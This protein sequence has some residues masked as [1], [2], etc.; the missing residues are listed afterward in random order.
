[1]AGVRCQQLGPGGRRRAPTGMVMACKVQGHQR[2]TARSEWWPA[3]GGLD[4]GP[5]GQRQASSPA[6]AHRPPLYRMDP[7]KGVRH[8]AEWP[9]RGKRH[10]E[11]TQ[12]G[13]AGCRQVRIISA[14]T[15]RWSASWRGLLAAEPALIV[16]Q[17]ARLGPDDRADHIRAAAGR[18]WQ[19]WP[20]QE[21][22]GVALLAAAAKPNVLPARHIPLPE[23]AEEFAGRL[24]LI[25][26]HGG[27]NRMFL[28]L[29]VYG[30]PG[31]ARDEVFNAQ[32]LLE[33]MAQVR[34]FGR[35]PAVVMG[36]LNLNLESAGVVGLLGVSGW[37]DLLAGAG[38]TCV[39][40][41]GQPSR[42]DYALANSEFMGLVEGAELRWDLGLATHAAVQVDLL[43]TEGGSADFR[44]FPPSLAGAACPDWTQAA[45]ERAEALLVDLHG[46]VI[47]SAL[48]DG[49]VE[50]AWHEIQRGM[51]CWL[52]ERKG[53]RQG[54]RRYAAVDRREEWRRAAS[55]EGDEQDKALEAALL[56]VRRL[57]NLRHH[58]ATSSQA[59]AI[60]R[61]LQRAEPVDEG[62]SSRLRELTEENL[63]AL[64]DEARA[65][66]QAEVQASR[67]RR[68][69]AWW[70]W[71]QSNLANQQGRVYRWLRDAKDHTPSMVLLEGQET[72]P[73][74]ARQWVPAVRGGPVA[75]HQFF[76]TAWQALWQRPERPG[77]GA[78][79]LRCLTTL[80]GLPPLPGWTAGLVRQTLQAMALRKRPGLDSWSV[81]EMRSQPRVVHEWIAAL[82]TEV[83]RTGQWPREAQVPEGVLL[84]KGLINGPLARRPIWLTTMLYRLWATARSK[85]VRAWVQ[86]WCREL[87]SVGA[88]GQ[89]WMLSVLN[90]KAQVQGLEQTGAAFDWQKAY[91]GVGLDLMQ[92]A[93]VAAGLPHEVLGPLM[94]AYSSPRRIRTAGILGAEWQ[95]S[96]GLLP[97]CPLAVHMLAM[98]T[99]PWRLRM[100]LVHEALYCR[101]YVDDMTVWHS[102]PEA[103]AAEILAEARYCGLCERHGLGPQQAEDAPFRLHGGPAAMAAGPLP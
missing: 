91:D 13:P 8:L 58:P 79:E 42:L 27:R 90:A 88:D 82:L 41:R 57:E 29:N 20:G 74:A 89:A 47:A 102:G 69:E 64:L 6:A 18:G 28:V 62:G 15:T 83:E 37:H 25:A 66:L 5:D 75:Q 35:V 92:R 76:A 12:P 39:P 24:Q 38:H 48:A 86:S 10:G 98:L 51:H 17:E 95:P 52:C 63:P 3:T 67:Q 53:V 68:R 65:A 19:L 81:P 77:A 56:R 11:A 1:M 32:L 7:S 36:D 14:N 72:D 22:D 31:G 71:V 16:S 100:Q 55:R 94:A 101:I 93:G 96:R 26:V 33:G 73:A 49:E 54:M 43:L 45:Q 61:A 87:P 78:E 44:V 70:C 84:P 99:F 23:L 97:G 9:S 80:P 40:T 21:E 34:S 50:Q 60:R 4:R 85:V 103:A 59:L 30:R 46:H 2:G